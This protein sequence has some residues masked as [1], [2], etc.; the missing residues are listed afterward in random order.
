MAKTTR[1][2]AIFGAED[3][4][5]IYKTY[6]EADLQSYN[7]ETIRK[8][9]VDYLRQHH[10]ETFNDFTESSEYIA[11][12]DLMAFMGQSLAFRSDLN[13]R[14]NFLDTA[15]R[16]DSVNNLATLVGYTPKRNEAARGYLKVLSVSTTENITDYNRNNLSN[17]TIRWNDKTNDD[18]QEQMT[19]VINAAL[20]DSQKI[21]QPGHLNTVVGIKTSEYQINMEPGFLP[22]VPFTATV[23]GTS[24][25]FEIVNGTSVA[26]ESIYEPAPQPSGQLN[27]LYRNDNQ[28]FA[29]PATGYFFYF[30]QGTLQTQDFTL[31]E[32]IAN[33]SIA[34]D[35][36]GINNHDVWL[37]NTDNT[38]NKEWT[39]VGNIYAANTTQVSADSRTYFSVT[40]RSDDRITFNFGDGVFSE[41]PVG[42]FRAFIRE[43][44][45]LEYVINPEEIQNT[46][47]NISYISKSGRN[48]TLTLT[49]GLTQ[50]VSNAKEPEALDDIKRRAP[51]R[52][53]TQNRMVNGEDYNNFPYTTYS[54]IIKSKAINRTNIGASRYLDL[55][56]PTGK[57]SSINAYA[58]DGLI[59]QDSTAGS[60]SFTFTDTN[61]INSVF[62]N[63]VEPLLAERSMTHFYY[64]NFDRETISI[65]LQW[66]QL[67]TTTNETSGY[68]ADFAGNAQAIGPDYATGSPSYLVP[69][70]LVKFVPP[71]VSPSWPTGAHF[72]STNKLVAG[73]ASA[74]GDKVEIW[75]TLT[76]V[77]FEGTAAGGITLAP[78]GTVGPVKLNN[79]VPS[80]AVAAEI[81]RVFDSDIPAA[82]EQEMVVQVELLRD[83][84]LGFDNKTSEWYIISADNL[85]STGA[86]P[87]IAKD[88]N[89]I[90]ADASWLV[91]FQSTPE[92]YN[93]SSRALHYIFSSVLETRFF[94]DK[95]RK[96][97]D[98]RTGKIVNDFI[99]VLKTNSKPGTSDPLAVDVIMD[100]IDQSV[101]SDGYVN[102]YKVEI[103]FA[104]SD[105]DGIADDPD[106]FR[107]LVDT[108]ATYTDARVYFERTIDFDNLE[109]F[110]PVVSNTIE[111]TFTTEA[112]ID[113]AK[114]E[115]TTGQIFYATAD[116]KFFK[117]VEINGVVSLDDVT[118]EFEVGTGR[119]SLHFQYRHNSPET[120][121]INPSVTN[122]IDIYVV[123]SGYHEAYLRYIQDVTD[124][125]PAP[126]VP[127]TDALTVLY[128]DLQGSKMTSDNVVLSSVQFKPLF[129]DKADAELQSY[130]KVVKLT[131]VIT[132]DSEIKS[133]V[134]SSINKY[135]DIDIWDFGDTFYFSELAAFIHSELGD[136][137]ASVV[138][139]PKD[140]TK[141]F[142]GLYEVRSAPYEIFASA[143]TVDDV[144]IID[145]LT[146]SNIQNRA[147]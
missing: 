58:S 62:R 77:E 57:Y 50:P 13:T 25:D 66:E 29:S 100:I 132:S 7:F 108:S 92:G 138:I 12:L 5:R 1:Q 101:E 102:D 111:D 40:S 122:I 41:I 23:D 21:G 140:T 67:T 16:T 104:D 38:G 145:A 106:F 3:W 134:I 28:G 30:K 44:N 80:G 46:D 84:G 45:G 33:R 35:R 18:W 107:T 37:F 123:T 61:D 81:I 65:D 129:G 119:D 126:A 103:S 139:V 117:I 105:S 60:F 47:I 17:I 73:P 69:K 116:E 11:M 55:V 118:T 64:E 79:F 19:T 74:P 95:S 49:I 76:S 131:N 27:L 26:S 59:F 22:V 56:D 141:T 75:A 52:F 31:A 93:V 127:T 70:S 42:D 14:E 9:F 15:E 113:L 2:T 144:N 48:E 114:L 115:Y 120:K 147:N 4:K 68:F 98:P 24:M 43:S 99:N 72:T 54:S 86:F 32:R 88:T 20:V 133:K 10:P 82:I 121:R 136:I 39:S 125:V 109:R 85:D 83:F 90:N 96:I 128:E 130:I 112:A 124:T 71:A 36:A 34:I 53:Y 110:L 78:A 146:A 97:Y 142:G 87:G 89:N 137:I 8:T 51:A 6:K 143:A 94:Y 135:F 91:L 63:Q